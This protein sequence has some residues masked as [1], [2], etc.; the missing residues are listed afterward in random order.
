MK[1]YEELQISIIQIFE[2]DVIRT[3]NESGTVDDNYDWLD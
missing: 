3:S 1:S 2:N